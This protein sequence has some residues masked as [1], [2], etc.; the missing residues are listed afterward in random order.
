MYLVEKTIR[1]FLIDLQKKYN[2]FVLTISES[3]GDILT[4]FMKSI[5]EAIDNF[6]DLPATE[7]NLKILTNFL[8]I[9]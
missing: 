3:I 2:E 4:N 5:N 9:K 7:E 1:E 8:S 6:L